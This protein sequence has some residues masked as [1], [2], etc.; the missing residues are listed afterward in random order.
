MT[1]QIPLSSFLQAAWPPAAGFCITSRIWADCNL[2]L[3]AGFQAPGTRG[4]D[5]I[6]GKRDIK[7]HGEYVNIRCR[8][9][10]LDVLS[11]HA[12]ANELIEWVRR[13]NRPPRHIFVTHGEPMASEALRESGSRMSLASAPPFPITW[14][15]FRLI[16]SNESR[17]IEC[18]GVH[19]LAAFLRG[20]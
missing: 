13:F 10:A 9:E 19:E 20:R 5:M 16:R 17:I 12:D 6:G 8:V 15:A 11:A 18:S 3:F 7:I 2:I 4:A 1:E 14:R